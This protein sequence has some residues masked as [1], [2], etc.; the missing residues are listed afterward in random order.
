MD[1]WQELCVD[2][3]DFEQSLFSRFSCEPEN[4][5]QQKIESSKIRKELVV[6]LVVRFAEMYHRTKGFV[7]SAASTIQELNSG[8]IKGQEKVITLQEQLLKNDEERLASLQNTVRDEMASV[9]SAVKTE[10]RSWSEVAA[11]NAN[12]STAATCTITPAKLREAVKSAVVEEDRSRNFL[13]FSKVETANED[14]VRTVGEVLGDL[15]EKPLIVEC[16]RIGIAQHGRPRPI[17][18]KLSSSDAVSHVLRRAKSLKSSENNRTTFIGPDRSKEERTVH[19]S[20]VV[21]MKQKM[22]AEPKLY[23]YIKGGQILSVQKL[24]RTTN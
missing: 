5:T 11:Q 22:A 2:M 1:T 6:D 20:L 7:T 18:V 8:M 14:T 10:I 21:E 4:L 12:Q 15:E 17:K 3:E 19:R 16:R 9:Q 23:H 13:I 24:V